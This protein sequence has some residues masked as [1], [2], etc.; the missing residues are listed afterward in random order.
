MGFLFGA[1]KGMI[2]LML[3][4]W[5]VDLF[6]KNKWA[7]IIRKESYLS[8]TF[9]NTRL[10]IIDIFHLTDPVYQ[11][12]IFIQDMIKRDRFTREKEI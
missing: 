12:E 11:G 8:K 1:V 5:T 2:I 9:T 6:P 10:M 4:Y 3:L 7:T